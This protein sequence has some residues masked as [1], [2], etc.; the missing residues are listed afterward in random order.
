MNSALEFDV[1]SIVENGQP[2][3][4]LPY[5]RIKREIANQLTGIVAF[6]PNKLGYS[7][8]EI[9]DLLLGHFEDL[10]WYVK[11]D[12]VNLKTVSQGFGYYVQQCFDNIAIKHYLQHKDNDGKYQYFRYLYERF[13]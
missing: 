3:N 7:A 1:K 11:N 13:T 9:D 5:L 10:G 8:F 6:D 12:W 2:A 4:E